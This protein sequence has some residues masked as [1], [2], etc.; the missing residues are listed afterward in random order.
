MKR[1]TLSIFVSLVGIGL[2]IKINH[3]LAI[4]YLSADGK[5]K[6]LFGIIEFFDLS[7]YKYYLLV[8][9]LSSIFSIFLAIRNK[10]RRVMILSSILMSLLSII[11]I[12][13]SLWKIMV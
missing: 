2:V 6:A 5:T 8:L 4:K 1:S 12:F 11:L 7:N 13:A 3:D 9:N 10:E